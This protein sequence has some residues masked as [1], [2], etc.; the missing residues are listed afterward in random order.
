MLQSLF[1]KVA[2][3]KGCRAATLSKRDSITCAFQRNLRNLR[4][5]VKKNTFF[6]EQLRWLLLQHKYEQD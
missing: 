6:T 3:L 4:N 1:N 5:S 2:G